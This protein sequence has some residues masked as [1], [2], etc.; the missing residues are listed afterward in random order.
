MNICP[1]TVICIR[2]FILLANAFYLTFPFTSS[3]Y[4][5]LKL[6][7]HVYVWIYSMLEAPSSLLNHEFHIFVLFKTSF[8]S[9]FHDVIMD[10]MMD[11][12]V[13]KKK[14]KTISSP[15]KL[16]LLSVCP[17]SVI[18]LT[19]ISTS[20]KLATSFNLKVN[21]YI[22][23]FLLLSLWGWV[24]ILLPVSISSAFRKCWD[25]NTFFI[26]LV[27]YYSTLGVRWNALKLKSWLTVNS[28][29]KH[30]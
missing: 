6:L 17:S 8:I 12:S 10:V 28:A 19:I 3:V 18:P 23:G 22:I 29:I 1:L 21:I 26:L 15:F 20:M 11:K 16:S 2:S 9:I 30:F 14:K 24:T 27:L 25:R 4:C 5:Q 7:F 13:K